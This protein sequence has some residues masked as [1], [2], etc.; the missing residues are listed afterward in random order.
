MPKFE[1]SGTPQKHYEAYDEGLHVQ[2]A[3]E[4]NAEMIDRAVSFLKTE[5]KLRWCPAVEAYILVDV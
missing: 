3:A 5:G 2:S 1:E 4:W